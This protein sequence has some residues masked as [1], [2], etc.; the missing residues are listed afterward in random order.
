LLLF[1]AQKAMAA[2]L[3]SAPLVVQKSTDLFQGSHDSLIFATGKMSVILMTSMEIC[4]IT[5]EEEQKY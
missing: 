1:K 3:Y 5:S 2:F 4:R